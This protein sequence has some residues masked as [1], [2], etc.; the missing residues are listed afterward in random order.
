MWA[1]TARQ[2]Q[3]ELP[4]E[5]AHVPTEPSHVTSDSSV[6]AGSSASRPAEQL[7][8]RGEPAALALGEHTLPQRVS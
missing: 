4:T 3:A 6:P 2:A 7:P 1:G 5:S 8:T